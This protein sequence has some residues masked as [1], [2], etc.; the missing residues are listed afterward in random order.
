MLNW[1]KVNRKLLNA[2]DLKEEREGCFLI[3]LA[4]AKETDVRTNIDKCGVNQTHHNT[5]NFFKLSTRKIMGLSLSLT[6][7][8]IIRIQYGSC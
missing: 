3:L 7:N 6:S 2:G 4:W 5:Y 8:Y 1:R